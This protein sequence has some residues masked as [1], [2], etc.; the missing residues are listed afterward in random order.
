MAD[1]QFDVEQVFVD[2]PALQDAVIAGTVMVS[3]VV[4]A[5]RTVNGFSLDQVLAARTARDAKEMGPSTLRLLGG[6]GLST[7]TSTEEAA[8]ATVNTAHLLVVD[9]NKDGDKDRGK[10]REKD[11]EY[12]V[13][14]GTA[15]EAGAEEK[16]NFVAGD[17]SLPCGI[18]H[19]SLSQHIC[20]SWLVNPG[21]YKGAN[22]IVDAAG[23]QLVGIDNDI[24][25]ASSITTDDS[26]EPVVLIKHLLLCLDEAMD[27]NFCPEGECEDVQLFVLL[28]G[29]TMCVACVCD[30]GVGV[31][32]GAGAG[33][34]VGVGDEGG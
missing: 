31:G 27:I 33:V 15:G 20:L 17:R 32:V 4:M 6:L 12:V 25:L 29:L 1:K 14:A 8:F 5:S 10:D 13:Q 22:F 7:E 11:K 19:V 24:A 26:G 9:D 2:N 18:T 3:A 23:R 16:E 28:E 30:V 21:D 34:G